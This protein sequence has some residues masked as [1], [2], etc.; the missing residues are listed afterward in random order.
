MDLNLIRPQLV[1][2]MQ[3]VGSEHDG[4]YVIPKN[5]PMVSTLVSFGL[6]DNWSFE[7]EFLKLG[8]VNNFVVYDHTVS[9]KG[10]IG[11]VN[12]RFRIKNFSLS[13]LI[14]RLIILFRYIVDFRIRKYRHISKKITQYETNSRCTNLM[15]V[16]S[17][18]ETN[19]FILKI[20]IEGDE[21]LLIDQLC[22][23]SNRVPLLI[24][25]FHDTDLNRERFETSIK[26]LTQLY[27]NC[28]VHANNFDALGKDGVPR[29]LEFTFGRLDIYR[30]R[31]F[32]GSL[33]ISGLDSPS[34]ANR[35]D[36]TMVFI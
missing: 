15:E 29:A 1:G 34:S 5:L 6:G 7:K 27:V 28:H 25:E 23:I 10:L 18:L 4:G 16:A 26:K 2:M 13:A 11:R 17:V 9:T 35:P 24:I 33:P 30:G 19:E 14:F 32:T 20:D 31:Q 21:Y 36:H 3:R 12:S 8:A 22:S